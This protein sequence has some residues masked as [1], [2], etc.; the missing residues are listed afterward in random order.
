MKFSNL[1]TRDVGG[2]FLVALVGHKRRPN[3]RERLE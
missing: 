1:G 3:F 2:T